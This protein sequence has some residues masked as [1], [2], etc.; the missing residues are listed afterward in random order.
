[1]GIIK[2]P[3]LI[4][5]EIREVHAL[6]CEFD[7]LA[8]AYLLNGGDLTML[9]GVLANRIG[10]LIRC[11]QPTVEHDLYAICEEIIIKRI[12]GDKS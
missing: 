12:L 7:S 9:V 4:P 6:S 11:G 2:F 10:E 5:S 3:L 1:M 8:N